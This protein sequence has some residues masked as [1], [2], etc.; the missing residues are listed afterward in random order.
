MKKHDMYLD[1]SSS[2]SSSRGHALS[3]SDFT[4]NATSTSSHEWLINSRASYYMDKDKAILS[5][6]N[7]CNTKQIFFVDDKSLSVVR[8]RTI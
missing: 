2:N 3:A 6:L 7:E 4:F 5:A 8:S 1:S